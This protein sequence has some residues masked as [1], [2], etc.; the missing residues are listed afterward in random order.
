MRST[1][2]K[3]NQR[4]QGRRKAVLP[5]RVRGRDTSGKLFEELAHTL[6][7]TPTGARLGAIRHQVET[8]E[9][10]TVCYRQRKMEFRVIWTKKLEGAAEYQVGLQPVAE[11]GE[12]WGLSPADFR[13]PEEAPSASMAAAIRATRAI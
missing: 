4:R 2:V 9:Q 13:A 7:V 10:L 11:D 12:A 5:V 1:G 3:A 8:L 6:D